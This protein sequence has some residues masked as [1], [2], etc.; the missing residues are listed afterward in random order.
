VNIVQGCVGLWG[1][2]QQNGDSAGLYLQPCRPWMRVPTE[3]R[4]CRAV[5]ALEVWQAKQRLSRTRG[6]GALAGLCRPRGHGPAEWKLCMFVSLAW[7]ALGHGMAEQ[8]SCRAVQALGEWLVKQ[9][10]CRAGGSQ[11]REMELLQGC[12]GLGR[13]AWQRCAVL[14][15]GGAW[16]GRDGKCLWIPVLKGWSHGDPAVLRGGSLG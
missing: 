11:P 5:Q 2:A 15:R 16:S 7:L 3:Q 12:A 13:M 1:V 14:C 9:R 8:R 10:S 4:S 6:C